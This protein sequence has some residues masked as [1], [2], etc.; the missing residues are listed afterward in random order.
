MPKMIFINLPVTDVAR[1]TTF[2]EAIGATKNPMFSD[3]SA[4]CMVF[5]ET[6]YA[7][8][9]GHEKYRGFTSRKIPNAHETAQMALCV[10]EESRADV[11][12]IIAA[13]AAAGGVGDVNPPEDHGFM[14]QRS[15]A[16]P[17][18]HIWE[19]MWMD[20]AAAAG[21]PPQAKDA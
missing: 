4:S 5:S 3:A 7:M 1:S 20:P 15:F 16:D 10:S 19:P 6:I 12:K 18:G 2:Y 9:V 11:D 13:A 21:G 14:Y 8:L 17:D